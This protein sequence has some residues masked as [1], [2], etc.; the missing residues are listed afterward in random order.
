MDLDPSKVA[1][2]VDALKEQAR[3]AWELAAKQVSLE[4]TY[5]AVAF[6]VGVFLLSITYPLIKK[7]IKSMDDLDPTA[8]GI[9]LLALCGFSGMFGFVALMVSILNTIPRICNPEWYTL[10]K[11]IH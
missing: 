3:P 2:I 7:A 9:T 4:T 6:V 11:L 5:G 10:A 1:Q 8:K